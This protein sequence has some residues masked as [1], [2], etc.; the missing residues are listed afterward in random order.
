MDI[1]ELR[2][3]CPLLRGPKNYIVWK[4]KME[5]VLIKERLWGIVCERRTKPES[6]VKA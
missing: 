4:S 1:I 3:A 2:R 6:S 5:M